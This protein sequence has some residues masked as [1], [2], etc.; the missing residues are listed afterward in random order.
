[1]AEEDHACQWTRRYAEQ[2]DDLREMK[3]EIKSLRGQAAASD[4]KNKRFAED[5]DYNVDGLCQA[6]DGNVCRMQCVD[7]GMERDGNRLRLIA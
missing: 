2:A 3:R 7:K 1:M 6:D 5:C 4:K